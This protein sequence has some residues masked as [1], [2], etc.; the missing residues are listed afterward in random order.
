MA[1][2]ASILITT[3]N[4]K[5]ALERVLTSLL[6]Q[7]QLP[8]EVVIADDGSSHSTRELIHSYQKIFPVPLIHCWQ[9]DK[10]FRASSVRNKAIAKMSADYVLM[11]DGDMY[12]HPHFIRDHMEVALKGFFVQ[13]SRAITNPELA[14]KI[15]ADEANS[16]HPLVFFSSGISNRLN[17]LNSSFLSRL[18]SR[19]D[20]NLRSTKT[21]NFAAW[22]EDLIDING[23][24]EDYIGWGREDSDLAARLLHKGVRRLKL[25]FLANAY[26]LHHPE[27]S[28]NQLSKNDLLL[29]ICLK[30]K[31]IRCENGIDKYLV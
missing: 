25:K 20:R 9:E 14:A 17:T 21:C 13:G 16:V 2:N 7:S 4:W 11:I 22:R 5:E 6:S 31:L 24:N 12:L 18:F 1:N 28:R 15:L 26:H 27:N 19:V 23:F 30:N 8:R 10:G 3:Y 29:E